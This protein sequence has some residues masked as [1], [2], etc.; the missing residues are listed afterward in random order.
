VETNLLKDID[1]I[2]TPP[3]VRRDASLPFTI[4]H[5]LPFTM[6]PSA[7]QYTMCS[8]CPAST[9]SSCFPTG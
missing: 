6:S 9:G 5:D 2:A 8:S 4:H 7:A 1:R 3:K